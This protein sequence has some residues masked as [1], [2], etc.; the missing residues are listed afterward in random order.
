M[1]SPT[2]AHIVR[3]SFAS[4]DDRTPMLRVFRQD[5]TSYIT[6]RF[7]DAP[8]S[9]K[10]MVANVWGYGSW[11]GFLKQ[12]DTEEHAIF[13][14]WS[15]SQVEHAWKMCDGQYLR[16]IHLRGLLQ[17]IVRHHYAPET[18]GLV[19]WRST[20]DVVRMVDARNRRNSRHALSS[21]LPYKCPTGLRD[22]R[23]NLYMKRMFEEVETI[24]RERRITNGTAWGR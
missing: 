9:P 5:G 2:S 12:S 21:I 16:D 3:Y 17:Q 6:R 8:S 10:I 20:E 15:V 19:R 13:K 24:D 4:G 18:V 11:T 14:G 23:L 1:Y 22:A 7:G